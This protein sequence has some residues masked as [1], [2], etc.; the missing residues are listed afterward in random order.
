[1]KTQ[2]EHEIRVEHVKALYMQG[3]TVRDICK[4]TRTSPSCVKVICAKLPKNNRPKIGRKYKYTVEY[5]LKIKRMRREGKT[6]REIA[7]S[8]GGCSQSIQKLLAYNQKRI[9][10]GE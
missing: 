2:R 10:E 5:L 8:I 1:M 6:Y 4:K 9:K 7:E 3:V